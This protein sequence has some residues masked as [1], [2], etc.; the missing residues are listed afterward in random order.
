MGLA[1]RTRMGL[2]L[3]GRHTDKSRSSRY[4]DIGKLAAITAISG[5]QKKRLLK[6][7]FAISS[8]VSL[9]ETSF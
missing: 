1:L 2:A 4:R 8:R 7:F 3:G 5:I 9:L 6:L